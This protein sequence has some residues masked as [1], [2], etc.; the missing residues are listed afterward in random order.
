[1][2]EKLLARAVASRYGMIAPI[3]AGASPEDRETARCNHQIYNEKIFNG[4]PQTVEWRT[5]S[6][7]IRPDPGVDFEPDQLL[8]A[9]RAEHSRQIANNKLRAQG[10]I[11]NKDANGK[12]TA[13]ATTASSYKTPTRSFNKNQSSVKRECPLCKKSGHAIEDCW[14]NPNNPNHRLELKDK[15]S[16]SGGG[17]SSGYNPGN[18]KSGRNRGG[19]NKG[20]KNDDDDANARQSNHATSTGSSGGASWAAATIVSASQ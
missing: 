13:A 19:R 16:S 15:K 8:D 17:K 2:H 1:Q 12:A 5:W 18:G 3:R 10:F 14:Q 6:M 9:I 11:I 4:L 7:K 20:G